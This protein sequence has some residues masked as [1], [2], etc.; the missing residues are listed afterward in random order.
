MFNGC[1]CT[2]CWLFGRFLD[3]SRRRAQSAAS[4]RV[5][6]ARP[7]HQSIPRNHII[8]LLRVGLIF[9]GFDAARCAVSTGWNEQCSLVGEI[10]ASAGF[11][12]WAESARF[13][14][15]RRSGVPGLADWE[16]L[17]GRR[18]FEWETG[19]G[20]CCWGESGEWSESFVLQGLGLRGCLVVDGRE[21][22][23]LHHA[24]ESGR[25]HPVSLPYYQFSINFSSIFHQFFINFP[26]IF[27]QFFINFPSIFHQFF[28]NFSSILSNHLHSKEN[29]WALAV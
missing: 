27:H 1:V 20:G 16:F 12:F 11:V 26:S 22:T 9:R 7:F 14:D 28:I 6:I 5:L 17:G 10:A 4:F 3:L 23:G 21:I 29:Y 18:G 24:V 13:G 2:A 15:C 8:V 25:Q 19:A